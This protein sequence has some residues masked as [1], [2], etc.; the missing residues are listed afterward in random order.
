[1]KINSDLICDQ[2]F[3]GLE[4]LDAVKKDVKGEAPCDPVALQRIIDESLKVSNLSAHAMRADMDQTPL[5]CGRD[6]GDGRRLMRG[7]RIIVGRKAAVR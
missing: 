4:A 3:N 1:M 5:G 6:L 7:R 2:S